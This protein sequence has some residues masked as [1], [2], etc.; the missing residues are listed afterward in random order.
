MSEQRKTNLGNKEVFS[1]N[2]NRYLRLSGKTQKE[3]AAA[4]KISTGT[5]CDWAKGNVYPRMDKV[6]ALA[7][8]FGIRMS[9]LV[10]DVN[11]DKETISNQDQE[12]F[13]LFH[14]VPIEKRE[15]ILSMIRAAIE[16]L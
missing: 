13:D 2:L 4:V 3:V 10:E 16:N 8:Y 15:L 9:D 11:V 5:F 14:K 7:E 12:V 6:Q 1:R